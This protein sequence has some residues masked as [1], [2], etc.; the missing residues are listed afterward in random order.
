MAVVERMA[1]RVAVLYLGQIVEIG[2]RAQIFE[3][4][5]HPY[6]RRLLSAVPVAEPGR[7]GRLPLLEGEVPSPVRSVGAEPTI[8]KHREIAPGHFVA[9]DA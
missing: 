7:R 6:T 3:T 5:A 4:P 8:L 9:A 2:S 1:H